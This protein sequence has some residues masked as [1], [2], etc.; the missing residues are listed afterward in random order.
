M[1]GEEEDEEVAPARRGRARRRRHETEV[2]AACRRR[3]EHEG[4]R[5]ERET[6]EFFPRGVRWSLFLPWI[7][8]VSDAF[9]FDTRVAK[10]VFGPRGR[11]NPGVGRA[12]REA[13]FGPHATRILGLPN[14][15]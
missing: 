7:G 6:G 8:R 15:A 10:C 12:P 5:D 4:R 2:T 11:I 13:G 1:E 14:E 9:H 3:E